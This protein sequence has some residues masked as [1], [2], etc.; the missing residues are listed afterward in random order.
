MTKQDRIRRRA[1]AVVEVG[2]RAS[3]L[4]K[5]PSGPE[6]HRTV[7]RQLD[8]VAGQR[9]VRQKHLVQSP[10]TPPPRLPSQRHPETA[11]PER[12]RGPREVRAR[13]GAPRARAYLCRHVRPVPW[14][15][16][17]TRRERARAD[18]PRSRHRPRSGGCPPRRRRDERPAAPARGG[19]G[20]PEPVVPPR[21][22][23]PPA[24]R[25]TPATTTTS[26]GLAVRS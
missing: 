3:A 20:V 12:E 7:G 5:A 13:G 16:D 26:R 22:R 24:H 6:R 17:H 19:R 11:P 23:P 1:S 21:R 25:R 14:L 9:V 8:A 15:D 10:G 18:L 4:R 2:H